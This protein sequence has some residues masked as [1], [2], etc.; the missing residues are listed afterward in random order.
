MIIIIMPT[1]KKTTQRWQCTYCSCPI[2][3]PLPLPL[4]LPLYT[5][6]L[7][8]CPNIYVDSREGKVRSG[9]IEIDD[10]INITA[11]RVPPATFSSSSST[12]TRRPGWQRRNP[13]VQQLLTDGSTV[14]IQMQCN[15]GNAAHVFQT[16][17]AQNSTTLLWNV[18]NTLKKKTKY[19]EQN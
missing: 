9:L 16:Q 1:L 4:S 6:D 17:H 12:T 19:R 3:P 11:T 13:R 7:Q 14:A 15:A 18:H 2:S 8:P 5:S 10:K